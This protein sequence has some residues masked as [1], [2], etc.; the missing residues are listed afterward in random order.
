MK[1]L[2]ATYNPAKLK[3]YLKVLSAKG[4]EAETLEDL[5]INDKA[6]ET[7][8][9]YEENA[10]EK[11]LFYYRLS[12]I[13]TIAEDGGFN[14]D[15]LNGE[16]GVKSRRWLGHEASDEELIEYLR[17]KIK[18]IPKE[19]RTA[20]LTTVLCLVKSESEIYTV[21]NSIEGYL[22]EEYNPNYPKGL[23]FRALF[24]E[25]TFD[26]YL[27][28]LT[29]EEYNQVNHRRKNIEGLMKYF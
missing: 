25:K 6:D 8:A 7:K 15:Y 18:E 12:K 28:D 3:D 5:K 2:L 29:E 23:P 4:I 10:R 27:M 21:K 13:P 14:I 9:T 24:I 11:A 19:Q 16:P 17:E 26:K 1:V 20:R 22:T